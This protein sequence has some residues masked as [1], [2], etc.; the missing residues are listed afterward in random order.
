[1]KRLLPTAAMI[2]LMGANITFAQSYYDD[3][4]YNPKKDN[5]NKTAASQNQQQSTYIVNM[6]DMDIDAYNRRGQYYVS[7][8]DTIG[9]YME[10]GED[11]VYTQQIQKFYNPTIVVDNANVLG[12]VLSNAYGNVDIIIN[13][14]GIPVFSPWYSSWS[15]PYYSYYN[16]WS[17]G[18]NF[19]PWGWSI[20]YNPWYSWNWGW[21][22][23]WAWGPSWSWGWGPSWGPGWGGPGWGWNR[24][25]NPGPPM[26]WRPNGNR[27]VGPNPG[28]SGNR[29]PGR[30]DMN[31][32]HRAPGAPQN[33]GGGTTG[34]P[35]NPGQYGG[36]ASRPGN[37]Q[38]APNQGQIGHRPSVPT[39]SNGR[40]AGVVNNNGKWEYNHQGTLVG[41]TSNPGTLNPV[42]RNPA[43]LNPRPA[44]G[45]ATSRPATGTV[46]NRPATG[47]VTNRKPATTTT[48]SNK[49]TTTT[50][51]ATT[52][53]RA[54][55]TVAPRSSGSS[56]GGFGGSRSSGGGASRG[57][58]G[59]GG[60]HR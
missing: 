6:G 3:I 19:G 7:D 47:T 48:N 39:N 46:T 17:W 40:P 5:S 60:R 37:N 11:F 21:G 45:T 32:A 51:P 13:T 55:S 52:T 38:S 44:T 16:P 35:V 33:V 9:M 41:G 43:G 4:Y 25:F 53:N 20:G 28:W 22:P 42:N 50:R 58:G 14:D 15:Y 18:V 49:T 27:P 2:F 12:D 59:G 34:R 10:N 57:T 24:P 56:F 54:P 23:S 29:N 36:N 30:G 26:A 8:I 31:M 1:M